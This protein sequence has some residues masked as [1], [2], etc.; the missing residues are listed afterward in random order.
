MLPIAVRGP[1]LDVSGYGAFTRNVVFSLVKAGYMPD[2]YSLKTTLFSFYKYNSDEERK[3]LDSLI[4]KR[5]YSVYKSIVID[6][7]PATLF[8]RVAGFNVGYTMIEVDRCSPMWV[9]RC[10]LMDRIYVPGVF[11]QYVHSQ[12]GV[13]NSFIIE[14]PIDLDVFYH[15]SSDETGIWRDIPND[16]S[17]Y[18][19][20]TA[21][22]YK[23][24]D[25]RKGVSKLIK[26]FCREF[27]DDKD[28][29]LIIKSQ[30][31]NHSIIDR[32]DMSEVLQEKLK[33]EGCEDLL[34]RVILYHR[35]NT[36]NEIATLYSHPN[37]RCFVSATIGEGAGINMLE[38]SACGLPV[39]TTNWSEHI[40]YLKNCIP[41][42]YKLENVPTEFS[43]IEEN[44]YPK[45]AKCAVVSVEHLMDKMRKFYCE[46]K[47][48]QPQKIDYTNIS[49]EAVGQKILN[50]LKD[51][52]LPKRVYVVPDK[53]QL[54]TGA[55]PKYDYF[56]TDIDG[57][58]SIQIDMLMDATDLKFPLES[59]NKFLIIELLEHL[60]D[61]DI[62]NVLV[63]CFR[64]L[65]PGGELEIHSPNIDWAMIEF[66]VK[67]C[68]MGTFEQIDRMRKVLLGTNVPHVNL[69]NKDRM[70]FFLTICGYE[71]IEDVED[72]L[73]RVDVISQEQFS[74]K[75]A[76]ATF[77]LR[78][79]KP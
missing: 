23:S 49:F 67:K 35:N 68:G 7:C 19:I 40:N 9:S 28:T 72:K 50:N 53:V 57:E 47:V 41:L 56:H 69:I 21:Q 27:K 43:Q 60:H 4:K 25:D 18:F 46:N 64:C 62:M 65:K 36:S 55:N 13:T 76:T 79:F 8:N 16:F 30:M 14:P 75:L 51:V 10:N 12:S 48:K 54:A 59:I 63:Q 38:A 71:R 11:N 74:S 2:V 5:E 70:K 52:E 73:S 22:I 78:C 77:K 24:K 29:A 6:I 17:F 37:I 31:L 32:I 66:A 45:D 61:S 34:N 20:T 3:L 33:E 44:V 42:D 58:R 1:I 39:M 26:A 15:R